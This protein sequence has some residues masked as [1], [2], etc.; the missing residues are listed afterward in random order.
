MYINKYSKVVYVFDWN[1]S[2]F[3]NIKSVHFIRFGFHFD[4]MNC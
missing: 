3:K 4:I 1:N 2:M